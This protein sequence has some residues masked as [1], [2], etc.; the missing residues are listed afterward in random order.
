MEEWDL[1]EFRT[2]QRV[3]YR[4]Y[5]EIRVCVQRHLEHFGDDRLV[6][7]CDVLEVCLI[8]LL[9]HQLHG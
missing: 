2:V 9:T 3:F 4:N 1:E 5:H 8:C 6:Y 7:S